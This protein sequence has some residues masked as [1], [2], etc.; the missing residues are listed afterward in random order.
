MCTDVHRNVTKWHISEQVCVHLCKYEQTMEKHN[1]AHMF[2]DLQFCAR[3]L[4]HLT[5]NV[6][7]VDK[8]CT[9]LLWKCTFMLVHRK[10]QMCNI[11]HNE[12][13]AKAK[14]GAYVHFELQCLY[15]VAQMC[16]W[17]FSHVHKCANVSFPL[18]CT[19]M[20][21]ESRTCTFMHIMVIPQ[22]TQLLIWVI[23]DTYIIH[24]CTDLS[25]TCTSMDVHKNL[26]CALLCN[27]QCT[28]M[29]RWLHICFLYIITCTQLLRC[30]SIQSHMCAD[31][32]IAICPACAIACT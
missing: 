28:W 3:L 20:H 6:T 31:V 18:M 19:F 15:R 4:A 9:D 2:S 27:L 10:A 8:M 16:I 21:V 17:L 12:V 7:W 26:R 30:A 24:M 25:W 29:L 5:F 14:L 13:H 11:V 1:I 22:S 23:S 32:H